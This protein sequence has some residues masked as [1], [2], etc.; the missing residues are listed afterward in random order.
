MSSAAGPIT[1]MRV[2]AGDERQQVAVVLQQHDRLSGDAP[3]ERALRRRLIDGG[4]GVGVDERLLEQAE[5]DLH[6]QHAPHGAVDER[7]RDPSGLDLRL[8]RLAEAVELRQL[9]V[10]PGR[11]CHAA[12]G[13]LVGGD[14]M[15][16]AQQHRRE[17][18]GDDHAVEAELAA[19]QVVE[20]RPRAAA[21]QAVDLVVRVHDRRE[22]RFAD[23][24]LERP[25]VHLAQLARAD[26]RR[27]VVEAALGGAVAEEVLAG[28]DDAA[29]ER[30]RPGR[31]ARRRRR[32]GR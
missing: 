12:G 27:R 1:A 16:R 11:Q 30:R 4:R 20:N 14:L 23:R 2:S 15:E 31:R 19:Q 6:P 17:V 25:R 21:R 10:E 24:R 9:D 13:A 3:G 28:G 29:G 7:D 18:V 5:R 22:P 26:V 8:E 32:G